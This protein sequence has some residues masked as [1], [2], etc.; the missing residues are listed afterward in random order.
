MKVGIFTSSIAGNY[1]GILQNYALQQVLR[2]LGHE[3][4]TI[5]HYK[6]YS[7]LRWIAGRIVHPSVKQLVPFPF[8]GRIGSKKVLDFAFRNINRTKATREVTASIIDKYKLD[9]IVVGS[10][11]VWRKAYGN[12]NTA[13]LLFTEGYEIKRVA[14]A[15][16]L[17]TE[18][19]EY[20]DDETE[21]CR[22]M[23]SR[24]NA[25]SVR[26]KSDVDLCQEHLGVS[27]EF[28]LDPT[29]LLE[30][31]HYNRFFVNENSQKK[32]LFAYILDIN[33]RKCEYVTHLAKR[34]NLRPIIM[35]AENNTRGGDSIERWLTLL[36]GADFVVTDSYHGTL[37]SIN[38]NKDFITMNNNR[39]GRS[40]FKSILGE[41]RLLSRM[42]DSE[43]L[44][45]TTTPDIAWDDVN[46]IIERERIKSLNFLKS[47]LL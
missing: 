34:L 42:I 30:S 41:T 1:G 16:S 17:G 40:R 43:D 36:H 27:P 14:Y 33:Q 29:L 46:N 2:S 5:D 26:E 9:A 39:R 28:V 22:N 11:Q 12:I 44:P 45:D 18:Q 24:F 35:S 4:I 8:Y 19:W 32:Y 13:F 37:F 25:V 10:D 23:V 20:S 6:P 38:F 47:S 7:Q 15:A 21:L 31:N 3:P